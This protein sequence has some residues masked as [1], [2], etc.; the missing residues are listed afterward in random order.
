[1]QTIYLIVENIPN[2]GD[3]DDDPLE[4]LCPSLGYWTDQDTVRARVKKL[5]AK[6]NKEHPEEL[7]QRFGFAP[8]KPAVE[9][10]LYL[11]IWTHRHGVDSWVFRAPKQP[12]VDEVVSFFD[13][14]F[15]PDKEETLEIRLVENIEEMK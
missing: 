10:P 7:N 4:C 12:T 14:H 6:Y 1:M 5:N 8:L 3:P 15:E 2:P 9:L 11:V 13:L